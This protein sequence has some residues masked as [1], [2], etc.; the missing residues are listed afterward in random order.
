MRSV[1]E[2][3]ADLRDVGSKV[4]VLR[5]S[6]SAALQRADDARLHVLAARRLLDP[7]LDERSDTVTENLVTAMMAE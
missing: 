1:D 6:R 2:I 4:A 5:A 7:L 3:D